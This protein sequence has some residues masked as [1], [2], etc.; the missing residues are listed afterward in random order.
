MRDF[1]LPGRSTAY[2]ENGMAAT[3]H[4]AATMAALNILQAGGNAV[5]AAI[6]A[7]ALQGVV[8]PAMTGIGG[9]CFALLTESDG[10]VVAF[11]GSGRA[12]SAASVES[13]QE[14]GVTD[15]DGSVHA[16]TVPGAVDAWAQLAERHGT[17]G[18]DELLQ[19]A[20]AAA[21]AGFIVTPR[22]A[23]DWATGIETLRRSAA[24][25]A[26][27]LSEGQAPVIGQRHRLPQLAGTLRQIAEN[28]RDAFY[29]GEVAEHMVTFLRQQGGLH[30]LDDFS[31]AAGAFVDPIKTSYRGLE[32]FECPPNGQGIIALLMLNILEGFELADL[33]PDGVERFHLEAEAT[34]FAFHDRNA[35]LADPDQADV[36]V[37]TLLDKRYASRLRSLIDPQRA[38]ATEATAL[39]AAH[40]DTVYLTVVDRDRNVVSLINSL[41]EGFGSGLVC[42]ETGVLFHN[43]G[44]SFALDPKHPNVIAPRKRPMHTIIPALALHDGAPAIGFGVMGGHYQPVGQVRALTNL[45]DFGF[46]PQAALDAPRAFAHDGQIDVERGVSQETANGLVRLGHKVVPAGKPLGG[47]QMIVIDRARGVLIGGSD[48]RKD[49]LA[50]GY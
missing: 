31:T 41:F 20:I 44:K 39:L 15:L 37:A 43:R 42:P 16:V 50:L 35:C 26:F 14:L 8:E 21:D 45:M 33:D 46:D 48:P 13:L 30:R 36:P 29:Q 6:A 5:D 17:K 25:R 3:S 32:V 18:L 40:R 34:R 2:A 7:V 22:V 11:N 24:G 10:G 49:G 12:P 47:G 38:L 28:G 9:D 1:E 19:P 23:Y 4:P 27:Y